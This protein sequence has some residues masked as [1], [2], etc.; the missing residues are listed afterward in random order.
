MQVTPEMRAAVYEEDCRDRGHLLSYDSAL[1][2]E[3]RAGQVIGPDGQQAHITCRR[4][5]KVWLVVE[6]PADDYVSATVALDARMLPQHRPV[7]VKRGP[8][9]AGKP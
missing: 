1:H 7:R 4:C 6:E 5:G 2:L 3:G 9:K 8:G